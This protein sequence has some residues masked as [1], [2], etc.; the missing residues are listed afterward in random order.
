MGHRVPAG[1]VQSHGP[2]EVNTKCRRRRWGEHACTPSRPLRSWRSRLAL[3]LL[4][5]AGEETRQMRLPGGVRFSALSADIFRVTFKRRAASAPKIF[6]R[7]T[8]DRQWKYDANYNVR[9]CA[10]EEKPV[11]AGTMRNNRKNNAKNDPNS[12]KSGPVSE[13]R[14][15]AGRQATAL[16]ASGGR[17]RTNPRLGF[18]PIRSCGKRQA[19]EK[20]LRLFGLERR[21]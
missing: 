9:P 21:W 7:N 13:V 15:D 18:Q 2:P 3:P 16:R 17:G 11:R 10:G 19:R 4:A 1:P 20:A 8:I 14:L 12:R 5:A 6:Q